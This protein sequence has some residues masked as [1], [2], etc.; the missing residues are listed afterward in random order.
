MDLLTALLLGNFVFTAGAYAWVW[1]VY[2]LLSK[3]IN[4]HLRTEL[5]DLKAQLHKYD[6]CQDDCSLC[7]KE[8]E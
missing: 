5:N 8:L 7:A 6:I 3:Q 4:N 1:T 2:L